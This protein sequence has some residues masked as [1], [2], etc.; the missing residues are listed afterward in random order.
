MTGKAFLATAALALV[1]PAPRAL[2]DLVV[3]EDGRVVK[4]AS[5][6][7]NDDSIEIY[8]AGGG[9][10]TTDL[11]RVERIVEDEV[12]PPEEAARETPKLPEIAYDLSYRP[13]RKTAP[14]S[15]WET[16]V[17]REAKRQNLDAAL[18]AA[19]I[20]AESN[21]NPRSVSR[22][23]AR[24]LMQLMPATARRLKVLYPFDPEQNVRGGV[25]Y[26]K[27]LAERFANRPELILAAYNAGEAAVE[28]FGGVPPYRETL[29]YVQ[30]VLAW[31][32]PAAAPGRAAAEGPAGSRQ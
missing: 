6:K 10:F 12:V 24:G 1:A 31:W 30:R 32:S 20:K 18:V 4:A 26:L 11:A 7:V 2:A 16:L 27:E 8:L 9:G 5:W 15:P 23:G 3:F 17:E 25:R 13:G 28:S 22:K 19:V 21:G 29:G 14:V